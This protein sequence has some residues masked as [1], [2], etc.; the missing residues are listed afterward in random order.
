MVEAKL[1]G[2]V[3]PFLTRFLKPSI[4][5]KVMSNIASLLQI[6]PS[7]SI[8]QLPTGEFCPNRESSSLIVRVLDIPEIEQISEICPI[9]LRGM[10]K[11]SQ[12]KK[13]LQS[14]LVMIVL[15][16]FLTSG[17]KRMDTI[18]NVKFYKSVFWFLFKLMLNYFVLIYFIWAGLL[19]VSIW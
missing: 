17:R 11:I 3:T 15:E 7:A 1:D 12:N 19:K 4:L 16:N 18:D 9:N 14:A 8:D 10:K 5:F 6:S 13:I 2:I